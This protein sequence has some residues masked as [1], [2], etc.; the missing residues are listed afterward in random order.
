[1]TKYSI[2]A[3]SRFLKDLKSAKNRGKNLSKLDA[4]IENLSSR[5]HLDS[6]YRDHALTGNFDGCHSV[7]L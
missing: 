3:T 4:V 1:M 2:K 5:I 6:T 7:L